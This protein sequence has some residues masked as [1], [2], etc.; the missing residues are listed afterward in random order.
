MSKILSI[1]PQL[2]AAD[3]LGSFVQ[4]DNPKAIQALEEDPS[5][6]G[7]RIEFIRL[8]KERIATP[9]IKWL[10]RRPTKRPASLSLNRTK[11]AALEAIFELME[12]QDSFHMAAG[13][14]QRPLTAQDLEPQDKSSSKT[15]LYVTYT[16]AGFV[17]HDKGFLLALSGRTGDAQSEGGTLQQTQAQRAEY[18]LRR[19]AKCL[20]LVVCDKVTSS[21]ARL[22]RQGE[23]M[24]VMQAHID[25]LNLYAT[26]GIKMEIDANWAF[27]DWM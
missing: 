18:V 3:Q 1:R 2:I 9:K 7:L 4:Q 12:N 21:H 5:L 27:P 23:T 13:V 14:A 22:Q 10:Q 20:S 6:W 17:L 26:K 24:S 8:G 16:R 15:S 11:G 19:D 25:G